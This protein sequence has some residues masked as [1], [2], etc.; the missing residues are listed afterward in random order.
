MDTAL[1]PPGVIL[2]M[3]DNPS[4]RSLVRDVLHD[5]G[6]RVVVASNHADALTALTSLRFSLLL[7]DHVGRSL[8]ADADRWADL[9]ALR[10]AAGDIPTVIFTALPPATFDGY[11][12]RGFAG[13]IA[14]P[15]DVAALP[16]TVRGML[17]GAT[18]G[19]ARG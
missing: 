17:V 5:E 3:D 10:R 7:A 18:A 12:A 9:D 8:A 19:S 4:L 2:I 13:L 6:F 1:A 11:G 16:A 15:G 14:K